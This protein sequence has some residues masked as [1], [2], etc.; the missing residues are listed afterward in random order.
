MNELETLRLYEVPIKDEDLENLLSNLHSLRDLEISGVFGDTNRL[1]SNIGHLSDRGCETIANLQPNLQSITL[2]FHRSIT[3][4]GASIL[5]ERCSN[6]RDIGLNDARI[7]SVDIPRLLSLSNSLLVFAF[8]QRYGCSNSGADLQAAMK[9]T[10][11]RTL[12]RCL[13]EG[14]VPPTGFSESQ[15]RQHSHSKQLVEKVWN[16]FKDTQCYN[17][18]AP[19][20][21]VNATISS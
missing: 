5:L 9:A 18:W 20:W 11:G 6:L 8:S 19:L 7:P 2:D 3:T 1:P 14:L 10:G 16:N 21:G 17:I 4:R 15:M 13:Y 12:L